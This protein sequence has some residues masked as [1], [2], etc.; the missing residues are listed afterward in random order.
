MV[1]DDTRPKAVVNICHLQGCNGEETYKLSMH[2]KMNSHTTY[3]LNVS[4][5]DKKDIP[6][7]DVLVLTSF[8]V[9]FIFYFPWPV[10]LEAMGH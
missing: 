3:L 10:T 9:I 6:E 2:N 8:F 7:Q 5:H 1:T 4:V